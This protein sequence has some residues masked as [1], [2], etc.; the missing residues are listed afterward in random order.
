MST[1][2]KISSAPSTA[3]HRVLILY[4]IF[5][6]LMIFGVL[7]VV[8]QS[9][10]V[11]IIWLVVSGGIATWISSSHTVRDYNHAKMIF[12]TDT[13][14]EVDGKHLIPLER[15]NAIEPFIHLKGLSSFKIVLRSD[16]HILGK[17][18]VFVLVD[19][20]IE[21]KYRTKEIFMRRFM[22]QVDQRKEFLDAQVEQ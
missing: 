20:V 16:H 3:K 2:R 17:K 10:V 22:E 7:I 12:M 9:M 4:L 14:I 8:F 15:I 13:A 1:K 19:A 6:A 11:G 18:I 5:L 21:K